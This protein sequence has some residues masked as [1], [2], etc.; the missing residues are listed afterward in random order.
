MCAL[1]AVTVNMCMFETTNLQQKAVKT[2]F[3]S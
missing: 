1:T 2:A 3:P